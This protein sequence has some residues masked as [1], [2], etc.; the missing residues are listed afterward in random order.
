MRGG[1]ED[2]GETFGKILGTLTRMLLDIIIR[3][4]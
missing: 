4:S 2:I 3:I 1:G